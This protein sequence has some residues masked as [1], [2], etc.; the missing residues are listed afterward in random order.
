M[1]IFAER[2]KELRQETKLT[3]KNFGKEIGV[4]DATIIR[5]EN[6][7]VNPSIVDLYNIAVRFNISANYLIGLED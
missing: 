5:W 2:L 7:N 4:S 1:K 6:D 3:A